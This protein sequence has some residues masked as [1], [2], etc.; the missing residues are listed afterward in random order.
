[1]FY[2]SCNQVDKS[3]GLI[4]AGSSFDYPLFSTIFSKY[5][6]KNKVQINYQS[7]GSGGGV[8]QLTNK[9]I[10]FGAS[11]APLNDEQTQGMG[12]KVL[13]IPVCIGATVVSYNI[14]GVKDTLNLS[15][16]VLSSIFLGK[17][18]NWDDPEVKKDNPTITF[19]DLMITVVHRSDGSG[20]SFIFTDFLS[21]VNPEWKNK[22]GTGTSVNWPVGLGG[23][24]NE[25]VSGL[26]KQSP[27]SIGYVELSYAME[28]KMSIARIENQYGKFISPT[29]AAI[30][31]SAE[32]KLPT[33][34]KTSI[35]NT[36]S[37]IG[38]PISS[39]SWAIIYKEQNY[40]NRSKEKAQELL[41]LF[42]WVVHGGQ[43]YNADLHYAPLPAEAI[44]ITENILKSA[45]YNGK[46]ILNP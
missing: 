29:I 44:K 39:F 22:V 20:T 3:T 24:G 31:A 41:Q 7:I 10:D 11:D 13:H 1:M 19:P 6:D 15:P 27:G 26:V 28:N 34:A 36:S 18:K 33:N 45:T 43:Q 4:G 9:T 35:T 37:S 5:H 46:V 17:I 23:K 30:S 21:K 40:K 2:S 14:P 16:N 8:L 12:A 38:Y 25:G 32:V 42:W